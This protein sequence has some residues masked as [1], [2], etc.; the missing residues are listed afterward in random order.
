LRRGPNGHPRLKRVDDDEEPIDGNRR[1]RQRRRVHTGALGIWNYVAEYLTK[2]PMA[3]ENMIKRDVNGLSYTYYIIHK[4]N[5][6][7]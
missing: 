5:I 7:S 4:H 6:I 2:H 3:C 1:Q